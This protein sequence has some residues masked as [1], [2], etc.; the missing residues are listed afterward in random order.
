MSKDQDQ[1]NSKDFLIGTLIG[2]IVGASIALLWAPKSGKELRTNINEQAY[3]VREKGEK[4]AE[5]AK[6]KTTTILDKVKH[7]GCCQAEDELV[8]EPWTVINGNDLEPVRAQAE[9]AATVNDSVET[10]AD[11]KDEQKPGN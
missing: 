5:T 3:I 6:Q 9:V 4:L 11:N 10:A 8:E 7:A 1:I 2:G